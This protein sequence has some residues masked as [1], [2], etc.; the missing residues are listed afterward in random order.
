MLGRTIN[1]YQERN[2]GP[3]LAL[4]KERFAKLTLGAFSGLTVDYGDD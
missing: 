1:E 4:V 3:L 2:Q